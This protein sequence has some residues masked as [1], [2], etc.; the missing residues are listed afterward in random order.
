MA[1]GY[2]V[3]RS[4]NSVTIVYPATGPDGRSRQRWESLQGVS[5]RVA[6]TI[7]NDRL[8]AAGKGQYIAPTKLTVAQQFA[9][10]LETVKL[11]RAPQT[12]QRY[13]SIV[14]VHLIPKLGHVRV[15]D[16]RASHVEAYF[17]GLQ[18][19]QNT[20][21]VHAAVLRGA[22]AAAVRSDLVWRNVV[23]LANNLPRARAAQLGII[24]DEQQAARFMALAKTKGPR[25][26]AMYAVFLTVG[27][28]RAEMAALRWRSDVNLEEAT[29]TINR[30]LLKGG[31]SAVYSLP[32][33][34][35][36]RTADLDPDTV[37]L[38]RVHKQAQAEAMMRS[39]DRWHDGDL[40]FC[41]D[42]PN[43]RDTLGLPLN[44]NSLAA[45]EFNPLQREAGV[46]RVKLHDLRH[47]AA[48]LQLR[49]GVDLHVVSARLGH[50][51]VAF[52][53]DTYAH[54]LPSQGK[55]AASLV[56]GL[57]HGRQG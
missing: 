53:L 37:A 55:A 35:K 29:L 7:L 17:A 31:S 16:L 23:P 28:R 6:R 56:G 13:E 21:A 22:L 44:V 38:L 32:K 4:A 15:Q 36:V 24:W 50:A 47:V 49:A 52:T 26:A 57:V 33:R 54:V 43:G 45:S 1:Q 2:V 12:Y 42:T 40:V 20:A 8:S 9:S 18:L 11:R 41:Q 19:G 34:G 27:C 10:Y 25:I 3:R 51:S 14:R 30:Q 46:P 5:M 39:R 48:T